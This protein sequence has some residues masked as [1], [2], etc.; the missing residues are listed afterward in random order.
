MICVSLKTGG[1]E[2]WVSEMGRMGARL[3]RG[4]PGLHEGAGRVGESG[5][6]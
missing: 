1:L 3:H 5:D 6:S 4:T 2:R